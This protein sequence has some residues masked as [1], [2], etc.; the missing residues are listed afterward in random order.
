MRE[1]CRRF[2][3]PLVPLILLLAAAGPPAWDRKEVDPHALAD[4]LVLPLPCGGAMAFRPVDVPSGHG[5]LDDRT[6][7]IGR[8]DPAE[9]YNE[10]QR[11]AWIAAPFPVPGS[12]DARRFYIGKYDVTR[13]QLATLRGDQCVA[14]TPGGRL[15]ATGVSWFDASAFAGA[16]SA[17]LL[18]NSRDSLPRR[19]KSFGFIRL[20]TDD[21]WSYAARGGSKVSESDFLAPTWPM[22]EGVDHYVMAGPD[23]AGGSAHAVGSMLP[24]PLGLYDM[25]GEVEQMM[26]DPYRLNRVGRAHGQAGGILVRG[27]DYTFNPDDLHTSLRSEVPPYDPAT[28]KATTL[29]TMGFRLVV[30]ADTLGDLQ[31][32]DR[33][34]KEF[35]AI[36]GKAQVA[37]NDP[38]QLLELLEQNTASTTVREALARVD[39]SLAS[40]ARERDDA[41]AAALGAQLEAATVLAMNV[42]EAG[43]TVRLLEKE[44]SGPTGL[45]ADQLAAV[46][47]N[48]DNRKKLEAGSVEGYMRLLR[49]I[50]RSPAASQLGQQAKLESVALSERDQVSLLAFLRLAESDAASL[51]AKHTLLAADVQARITAVP[52]TAAR[53]TK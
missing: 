52:A 37:A 36:A 2:R 4:D 43:N 24:N 23:V 21:E 41:S 50:S 11:E 3:R 49:A 16:W 10:F 27:G 31:D 29:A 26:L 51:I 14:P 8:T 13:D 20:P 42:W 9:G 34:Q 5:L 46:R 28:N 35:D 48:L 19:G 1:A 47:R 38:R 45:D 30:S 53:A 6:M 12:T 44:T 32:T 17:W 25:L 22:P 40:Q 7:E 39:A 15:P 18:A 33:A